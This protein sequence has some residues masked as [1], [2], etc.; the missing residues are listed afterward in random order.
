MKTNTTP[1]E[2]LG[3]GVTLIDTGFGRKHMA[4]A[5]LIEHN[6][7][8]AFIDSGTNHSVATLLDALAWSGRTA[9]DVDWVILTHIHLD[10][11]GG[12]GMLM[13]H[14]PNARLVVHPQGARHMVDPTKIMA[15]VKAVYGE[16]VVARDYGELVGID[17]SKIITTED[18]S[19]ISLGGRELTFLHTPGH[20]KHHHCIWDVCTRGIFT[21]DTLGVAYRELASGNRRHCIPSSSP[22]QFD[23]NA[24]RAS[25][26]RIQNMNPDIAFLTH[27]GPVHDVGEQVSLL[28]PQVE[29][30]ARLAMATDGQEH[31]AVR[32]RDGLTELYLHALHN[33]GCKVSEEVAIQI[34]AGDIE[35]NALG[36]EHWVQQAK[37]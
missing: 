35:L 13:Q 25:I 27:F 9:L 26:E 22:V 6:G 28:L 2:D 17:G 33:C 1:F 36:L 5:Y 21:G 15:G 20:A 31:S 34:L 18:G 7:R 16:E 3:S 4:A 10:H 14:L 8:A 12:A 32:L 30:M 29:A 24:L 37:V 11:A 19:S 23:P